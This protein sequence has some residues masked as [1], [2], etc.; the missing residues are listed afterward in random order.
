MLLALQRSCASTV[1]GHECDVNVWKAAL[2][3]SRRVLLRT[4]GVEGTSPGPD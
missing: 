1:N 4:T 2:H 3:R